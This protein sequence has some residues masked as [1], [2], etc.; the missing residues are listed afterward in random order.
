MQ[1]HPPN[2]IQVFR[3]QTPESIYENASFVT[4]SGRIDPMENTSQ[5]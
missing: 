1:Q 3:F 4:E 2:G 5:M